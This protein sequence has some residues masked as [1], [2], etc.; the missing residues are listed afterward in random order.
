MKL[1]LH[2]TILF[3]SGLNNSGKSYFVKNKILPNYKCLV[4]DPLKEY[5]QN[6]CD[7]YYP[8]K[9]TY[10]AITQE[11]ENFIKKI[12]IPNANNYDLIVWEEASRTF[13]NKKE[14]FPVMRA[15]LDTY[16]HY[17][18]VGLVFICRRA[19]QIQTDIPSLAHNLICFGNKGVA[20]I[21]RLNSE[22][23]GLGDVVA[24][25][26]NYHFVLVAQDRTFK[27]MDPI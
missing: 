14:L 16:R 19:S 6:D 5:P 22:S 9:T 23:Q 4:H 11:N 10:P 12:V 20:D 27:E 24:Q 18:Q 8:K 21:Q 3:V 26:S 17:N 13:P 2:N 15:F 7:V 1:D 25:L